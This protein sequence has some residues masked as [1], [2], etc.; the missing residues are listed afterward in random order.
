VNSPCTPASEDPALLYAWGFSP[1]KRALVPR[2]F[3]ASRVLFLH[4]REQPPADAVLLAWGRRPLPE[5]LQARLGRDLTRWS[6]ED[7]FL[8]SVGLGAD[9]IRPLSWVVDRQGLYFDASRSSDLESYLQQGAI[10][11]PL[12]QRAARLRA[13]IVAHA[14]TKYNLAG[15]G[16]QRP[17]GRAQVVLATGQVES[18]ASVHWGS[19]ALRSNLDLLKA[20]RAAR[21]EAWVVY[22]PHPDVTA[23]LRSAGPQEAQAGL[24]CDEIATQASLEPMLAQVDEV[25]TLTSLAGFEALLRGVPVTCW[26][27][28]F[29]A[30]WGL[31]EDH[32]PPVRRTRRLSLDDLVAGAL[33]AYPRYVRRDGSGLCQAEDALADLLA[34]RA[35]STTERPGLRRRL[36]RPL[37][38]WR[39]T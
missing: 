24:W 39:R 20:V 28:P 9:L 32:H 15:R 27:Q 22:K 33:L 29:Y 12:V 37:L 38:R 13:D 7:G 18:D 16:W 21:P 3:P 30:G 14:V 6:V 25:H 36:L 17:A 26:G 10:P 8:R 1:W 23:G 2:F 35:E 11:A 19:P 31:T 5:T 4:G 34:W